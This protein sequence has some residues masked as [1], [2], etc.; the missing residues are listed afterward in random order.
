MLRS[1]MRWVRRV[2]RFSV[3]AIECWEAMLL[4]LRC[5]VPLL[6]L[7]PF[8]KPHPLLRSK[9]RARARWRCSQSRTL[10]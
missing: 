3:L 9:L 1:M 2:G 10:L 8:G 4:A 7:L 6:V 5:N